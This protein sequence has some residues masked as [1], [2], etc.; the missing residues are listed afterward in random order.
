LRSNIVGGE[1]AH[2][3]QAMA[4]AAAAI[5]TGVGQVVTGLFKDRDDAERAYRSIIEFGYDKSDINLVM[6]DETRQRHFGPA[7]A[8][9]ELDNKAATEADKPASGNELGGP[10]GGTM[11]TIAPV[12]A[13]VGTL[14][15]VP[16]IIVAGPIAAALAA[17]GAVGIAGGIMGILND[18]GVP[19]T[20]LQQY[21]ASIR[22]GGI[23]IAVKPHSDDDAKELARRLAGSGGM[24]VQS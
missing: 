1:A 9:N 4:R 8:G 23:L 16:G 5:T 7:G 13:A 6:S 19:K 24:W 2:R 18:W 22:E 15:L 12:L 10:L 3:E 21:E 17:A 14:L 20:R 11:G